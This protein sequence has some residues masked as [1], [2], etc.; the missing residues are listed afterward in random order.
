MRRTT[1]ILTSLASLCGCVEVTGSKSLPPALSAKIAAKSAELR[2]K[3]DDPTTKLALARLYE[4]ASR[5]F[6]AADLYLEV[7]KTAPRDTRPKIG[8]ARTYRELGYFTKAFMQLRSC[9]G[10]DRNDP[11][12]L[13][14]T[15][16]MLRSDGSQEGLEQARFIYRRFLTVAGTDPRRKEVEK[17]VQQLDAQ[18]GDKAS[19]APA[20]RPAS[21][22]QPT[23]GAQAPPTP[24]SGGAGLIPDHQGPK[25]DSV[26]ELNPFGKAIA[27][28]IQAI[29]ANDPVQAE[30]AF[31]EALKI[32]PEDPGALAGLAETLYQQDKIPE[33]RTAADKA[34]G[35]DPA[36][37]QARW[38]YGLIHLRTGSNVAK[39]LEA[40]QALQRDD[41][42]FA[43]QL[44]VTRA[45]ETVGKLKK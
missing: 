10:L 29:R 24:N 11:D 5:H 15:G 16:A 35:A 40:W 25:D 19:E 33:A 32:V 1:A 28:A 36:H 9:L 42:D 34:Y 22:P 45:L 4:E 27:R 38:V 6:E 31:R 8:L 20:S 2:Q 12:C 44:G 21:Q 23:A 41:P 30:A 7:Q 43:Q 14:L 17:A 37:P 3:P 18:L 26:G 13:F 39:G